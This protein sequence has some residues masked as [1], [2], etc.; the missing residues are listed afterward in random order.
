MK[1]TVYKGC[2]PT[3]I[4]PFTSDNKIDYPAV[5]ALT[6][7]YIDR[8]ADG[9][10]AVC[11]SSEMFFLSEEEKTDLAKAVVEAADG[12]IKVIASG[13]TA[14]DHAKQI[15]QLGKMGETG[16]DAVVLVSNRL[17]KEHEGEDLFRKNIEDI[18]AQLPG[19]TFG[20]YECPYPYLRLLDDEFL[21]WAATEDKLVF[22][23]DVSCSLEIQRRRVE[24]VKGTNLALFNANT[25]TVLD[26]WLMGYH[27]YNG[28]MANFHI[29]LYAWL[30]EHYK[31]D[32]VLAR[33]VMDHLTVWAVAEARSYP[34]NAKY[35]RNL[36]GVPMTLVT[37]TKDSSL[38][39][40]NGRHEI[41]SLIRLEAQLRARLGL[42]P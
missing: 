42:K 9:I 1:D 18:F 21:R 36:T 35:H 31:E 4:T 34:V 15:D 10:F 8:G 22:L 7:W 6:R 24:L 23:K 33:E 19:V 20:M 37:R 25:A 11:Q 5:E 41:A 14:D 28:V 40:E 13:H 26:S 39:N 17:A 30:F 12:A 16:V 38:L 3:M 29:D 2:W 27:G 32:P